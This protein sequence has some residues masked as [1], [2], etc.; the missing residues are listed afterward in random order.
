MLRAYTAIHNRLPLVLRHAY[1]FGA[2]LGHSGIGRKQLVLRDKR[3]PILG[4]AKLLLN[5]L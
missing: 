2:Y 5:L 3:G 4:H 1:G